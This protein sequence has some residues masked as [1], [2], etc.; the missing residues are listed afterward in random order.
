MV[1]VYGDECLEYNTMTYRVRKFKSGFISDIDE[2]SEGHQPVVD[3]V[4][5]ERKLA[6]QYRHVTVKQLSNE[7]GISV[8]SIELIFHDA[9]NINKVSGQ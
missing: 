2:T 8:G 1:Q 4:T 5:K 3:Y 9:L 6:Q 7:T